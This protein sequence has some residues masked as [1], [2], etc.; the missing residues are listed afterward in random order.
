MN[1]LIEQGKILYYFNG[2]DTVGEDTKQDIIEWLYEESDYDDEL[3][4]KL[5]DK[6]QVTWYD[7]GYAFFRNWLD[8]GA[9]WK[10]IKKAIRFMMER[11]QMIPEI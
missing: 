9:D 3:Y 2:P 11:R 5:A 8:N 10:F 7:K 6:N 1:T 4:Q